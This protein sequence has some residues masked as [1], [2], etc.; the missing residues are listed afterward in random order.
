MPL[1]CPHVRRSFPSSYSPYASTFPSLASRTSTHF[2]M[3]LT[4]QTAIIMPSHPLQIWPSTRPVGDQTIPI[5]ILLKKIKHPSSVTVKRRLFGHYTKNASKD[6][7]RFIS[8]RGRDSFQ[9]YGLSKGIFYC[10][11]FYAATAQ[12]LDIARRVYKYRRKE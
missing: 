12:V 7:E 10:K 8:A 4:P 2:G 3:P 1:E 9:H 6:R 11:R 5:E